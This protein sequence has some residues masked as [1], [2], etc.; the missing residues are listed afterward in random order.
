MDDHYRTGAPRVLR[1]IPDRGSQRSSHHRT[2]AVTAGGWLTVTEQALWPDIAKELRSVLADGLDV[3]GTIDETEVLT[4]HCCIETDRLPTSSV[5]RSSHVDRHDPSVCFCDRHRTDLRPSHA[6]GRTGTLNATAP[7]GLHMGRS[8]DCSS[9]IR[10]LT[11]QASRID[12]SQLGEE[13]RGRRRYGAAQPR[14]LERAGSARDGGLLC[15]GD[16][17]LPPTRARCRLAGASR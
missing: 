17:G 3:G 2:A 10:R 9:L 4:R 14:A 11:E 13:S 7:I 6:L 12:R 16:G 1:R 15:A 8:V 5:V